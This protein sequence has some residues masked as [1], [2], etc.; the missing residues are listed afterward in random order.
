VP[1]RRRRRIWIADQDPLA[2]SAGR[3]PLLDLRRR[4]IWHD[5][6]EMGLD[7]YGVCCSGKGP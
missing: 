1:G 2:I 3:T 6:F 5:L 4:N 7:Q